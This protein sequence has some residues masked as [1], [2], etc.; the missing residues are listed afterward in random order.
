VALIFTNYKKTKITANFF[1][2]FFKV[3][4]KLRFFFFINW[5]LK[6]INNLTLSPSSN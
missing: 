3:T 6:K 1:F 2:F 4:N 5:S